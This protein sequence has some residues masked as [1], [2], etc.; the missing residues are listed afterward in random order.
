MAEGTVNSEWRVVSGQS[1]I[2][3]EVVYAL[4][5]KQVLL[6]VEVDAGT[7]VRQAIE[8]SGILSRFPEIELARGR[9]GI[10]GRP[11]H[12]DALLNDGDRVE[13]YRPLMADPKQ[14]R[15]GRAQQSPR[16]GRGD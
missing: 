15:Q 6:E 16:Q 13:I 11:V 7:N 1:Q 9:V 12:L 14:A 3:I 2:K 5:E 4:P 8:R 10:F